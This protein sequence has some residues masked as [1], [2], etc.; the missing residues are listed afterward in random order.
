MT[1]DN[2]Q[3]VINDCIYRGDTYTFGCGLRYYS[4][5]TILVIETENSVSFDSYTLLDYCTVWCS[6]R[7]TLLRS[8]SPFTGVPWRWIVIGLR[9]YYH[10][11]YIFCLPVLYSPTHSL[12]LFFLLLLFFSSLLYRFRCGSDRDC[13]PSFF[14]PH[15]SDSDRDDYCYLWS[16]LLLLT[17]LS[18]LLMRQQQKQWLLA[19]YDFFFFLLLVWITWWW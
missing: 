12:T 17:S 14:E 1:N 4:T 10:L 11:W 9:G 2:K 8:F 16:L 7:D 6:W 15:Y 13:V 3:S 19:F 5:P 18:L